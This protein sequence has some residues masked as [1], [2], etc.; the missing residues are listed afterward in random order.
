MEVCQKTKVK[1]SET[2][3]A[4]TSSF[5]IKYISELILDFVFKTFHC[6]LRFEDYLLPCLKLLDEHFTHSFYG[7]LILKSSLT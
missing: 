2:N 7:S 1:N 6:F 5:I 4:C 3:Y